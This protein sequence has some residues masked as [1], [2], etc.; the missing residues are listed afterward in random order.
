MFPG[1][2]VNARIPA[3]LLLLGLLALLLAA[4]SASAGVRFHMD[5]DKPTSPPAWVWDGIIGILSFVVGFIV[6]ATIARSGGIR[7]VSRR[8]GHRR[9]T[10]AGWNRIGRRIRA[11]TEQGLTEW[12]SAGNANDPDWD[13]LSRRIE[14]HIFDEMRRNHD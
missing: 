8:H 4:G 5:S 11:G 13:D 2:V 7:L 3:R 14:E 10:E 12:R 1:G 6:A 9:R